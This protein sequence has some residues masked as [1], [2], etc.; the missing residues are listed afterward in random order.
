[1]LVGLAVT[2]KTCEGLLPQL[3]IAVTSMFPP[4]EPDV[5]FIDVVVEEPFHPLGRVQ[6]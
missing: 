1:V 5:V 6:L 4:V 2:E 3:L